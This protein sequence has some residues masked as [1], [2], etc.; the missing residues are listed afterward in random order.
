MWEYVHRYR[1]KTVC[2]SWLLGSSFPFSFSLYIYAK[3]VQLILCATEIVGLCLQI[4]LLN[5]KNLW[6]V[7]HAAYLVYRRFRT[8]ERQDTTF[9]FISTVTLLW[10]PC[11]WSLSLPSSCFDRASSMKIKYLLSYAAT[12]LTICLNLTGLSGIKCVILHTFSQKWVP[13]CSTELTPSWVCKGLQP[14]YTEWQPRYRQAS[15]YAHS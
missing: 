1:E 8:K 7:Q 12:V 11:R 6:N 2:I 3:Q 15:V 4:R 10:S 13:L 14:N 9:T 5:T